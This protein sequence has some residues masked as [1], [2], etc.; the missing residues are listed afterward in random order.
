[1]KNLSQDFMKE[2]DKICAIAGISSEQF[3]GRNFPMAYLRAMVAE[4]LH[5]KKGYT[6][7]S[8]EPYMKRRHS[9]LIQHVVKL[10][11]VKTEKWFSCV[12]DIY[13]RYSETND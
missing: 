7:V 9:A 8:L 6:W 2:K 13:K 4:V 3:Y 12:S 10:N 11:K 5:D 1:M